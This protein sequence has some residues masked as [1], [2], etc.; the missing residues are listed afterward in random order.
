MKSHGLFISCL[1][2]LVGSL[3]FCLGCGGGNDSESTVPVTANIEAAGDQASSSASNG[4]PTVRNAAA[5]G[6]SPFAEDNFTPL[7]T[8]ADLHPKVLMKTSM[9]DVLIELDAKNA[10]IT[11]DNFLANY[12][13]RDFY[14][15]T[16]F[17]YVDKGSLVVGGG[18][19]TDGKLKETRTEVQSEAANGLKNLRGTIAM[20]RAPDFAHS[21]T[22]QFFI[23]LKENPAFDHQSLESAETYGYCVFGKVVQGLE[24]LDKIS[25]VS[26][27]DSEISPKLP[28][29]TV[30]IQS[31]ELVK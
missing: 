1:V 16:I 4:S 11:V 19:G 5:V 9:G 17:H 10:P 29:Q 12:V 8:E 7:T 28:A 27:Q 6:D 21:A 25:A 14:D 31:I 22:S 23:N 15:A 26:V 30:V 2:V 24:V 3:P 18:Y 20:A 13:E